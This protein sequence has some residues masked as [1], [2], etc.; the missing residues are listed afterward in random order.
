MPVYL[1]NTAARH[2][3][4]FQPAHPG[5]VKMYVCGPTVY[6][7]FHVGNARAFIV[8]DILRRVLERRGFEVTYVQNITDVDDKI[9]NRARDEGRNP[10]ELA[11]EFT[12]AFFQDLEALGCRRADI[13]PRA[14]EHIGEIID[15]VSQ[16]VERQHAY[17]VDGDVFF[18]VDSFPD[19]GKLSGK[20]INELE[21]GARVE[22]DER[23]QNPLDFALWK[24][25]KPGEPAWDSPWGPGRPGWHIECSAMSMKYLGENFDIHGGGVDLLFPHHENENAQSESLTG[26]P[27]A[28]YWLHNGY[29]KIEGEKMSKS[30]GNFRLTRDVLKNIASRNNYQV[31]RFFML[32]AHYRSPLDFNPENLEAAKKGFEEFGHTLEKISCLLSLSKG[33]HGEE[34][35]EEAEKLKSERQKALDDFDRALDDDLNTAGAMG[36]MLI[37]ANTVRQLMAGRPKQMTTIRF[38]MLEKIRNDLLDMAGVLGIVP[39]IEELTGEVK[40]LIL[41]RDEDRKNKR[42]KEADE[43]RHHLVSVMGWIQDDLGAMGYTASTTT[44]KFYGEQNQKPDSNYLPSDLKKKKEDS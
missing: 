14:T 32:S 41:A 1:F 12:A 30:L 2:K 22:I 5:K 6:D 9:I 26:K 44:V 31:L 13:T 7:Y 33:D 11:G 43:K 10:R 36:H 28:R 38:Q 42:W 24:S 4:E 3:E 29:L 35:D 15:L 27:L 16:L 21:S 25:A 39:E 23:K 18:S 8:F 20:K 19:Y 40:R 17:L 37:L 34:P